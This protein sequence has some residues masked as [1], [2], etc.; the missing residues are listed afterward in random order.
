MSATIAGKALMESGRPVNLDSF[1]LSDYNSVNLF[2]GTD[3][4]LHP[5]VMLYDMGKNHVT[6]CWNRS[7]NTDPV[8]RTVWSALCSWVLTCSLF[9]TRTTSR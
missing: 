3:H 4:I 2:V 8:V 5:S 9:Q 1:N 6:S 7:K